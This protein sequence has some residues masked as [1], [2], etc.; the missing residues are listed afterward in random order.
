MTSPDKKTG[1]DNVTAASC[2]PSCACPP[3]TSNDNTQQKPSRG[4]LRGIFKKCAA[5]AGSG[6]AGFVVGH[7][8]CIITPLVIAA[9][10]VT[11]AAAGVSAL[12]LAFGAAA[13]AGGLYAWHKLRGQHASRFE[14]RLVVGSAVVGLLTST[15]MMHFGGHDHG[16]GHGGHEN[17]QPQQQHHQ[18]HGA[19]HAASGMQDNLTPAAA[20]FYAR[21]DEEGQQRLRENAQLLKMS[22]G[23]YLNGICVTPAANTQTSAKTTTPVRVAAGGPAL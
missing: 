17:H 20:T 10:G 5:C 9:A 14:K 6:A 1:P 21:M 22:L 13:T 4:F 16:A 15:A 11:T 3:A 7:A 18:H 2:D 12:A 8:G 23:E 19:H